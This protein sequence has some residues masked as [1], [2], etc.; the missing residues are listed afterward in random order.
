MKI[1]DFPVVYPIKH[2]TDDI[3]QQINDGVH[4]KDIPEMR[5]L[6]VLVTWHESAFHEFVREHD[7]AIE[8]SP[9]G[10]WIHAWPEDKA[11]A[12]KMW[13]G[14]EGNTLPWVHHLVRPSR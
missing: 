5:T 9:D 12:L 2:F 11:V 3:L 6:G 10:E 13:L 4:H 8:I 1:P 14:A 7:I